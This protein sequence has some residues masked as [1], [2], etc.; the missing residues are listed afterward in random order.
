MGDETNGFHGQ[1][2]EVRVWGSALTKAKIAE[3]SNQHIADIQAAQ[4]DDILLLYYDFNQSGG[5]VIDRTG[6][7]C[8]AQRIGFGP[9][10]DAWNSALGVFTLDTNAPAHGDVSSKYLTNYKNPFLTASGTVNPNNSSRFLVLAMRTSKSK[11]KD[12]NAIKSG[13]ITTGAHIDTSHGSDITFETQW[14]EFA[15]PLL[16]YRLWQSVKLPAGK[17]QFSVTFSDGQ[18]AQSS[19]LVVSEGT[20]LV[21]EEKCEEKAIAWSMLVDGSLSFTLEE[22]TEVSLGIIVNLT[23]Q[24]SFGIKAFKL[25]GITFERISPVIPTGIN[26]ITTPQPIPGSIYNIKGE[27]IEA[28]QRGINI[29]DNKKVLKR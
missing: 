16:D 4:T 1:I 27:R 18:D 28:P 7:A 14:S 25:E 11:W 26:D 29:I 19:R 15:T 21:G 8:H 3:Y 6:S 5:N 13:N 2:D 23:G 12:L 22:E 24:A 20:S 17:Y 10:G 9:D